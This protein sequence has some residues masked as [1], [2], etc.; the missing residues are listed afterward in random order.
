[1]VTSLLEIKV[2]LTNSLPLAPEKCQLGLER[3][4]IARNGKGSLKRLAWSRESKKPKP[5]DVK[6]TS[7][8]SPTQ[9]L[10]TPSPK[11]PAWELRK[12]GREGKVTLKVQCLLW[13]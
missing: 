12:T 5:V 10:G 4:I 8:K 13:D 9:S 11:G 7:W 6:Q 1:M 3:A 2:I